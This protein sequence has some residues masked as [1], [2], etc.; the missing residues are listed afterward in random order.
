MEKKGKQKGSRGNKAEKEL[1]KENQ[2]V[3]KGN[4]REKG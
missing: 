2:H 3:T 4:N 1:K